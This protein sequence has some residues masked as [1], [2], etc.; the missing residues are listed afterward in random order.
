MSSQ[1]DQR[2][3]V[4]ADHDLAAAASRAL[5]EIR[6]PGEI[7]SAQVLTRIAQLPTMLRT[8]GVLPTLA[9]YAAKGGSG[10]TAE[11]GPDSALELAYMFVGIALREQVC[12]ALGIDQGTDNRSLDVAF[13]SDLAQR[14]RTEP[15]SHN[16]VSARLEQFSIWLRRL[17]EA[18]ERQQEQERN[19]QE[20]AAE[21]QEATGD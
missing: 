16:R 14:L 9:F 20:A 18:L 5:T 17:A 12:S 7:V 15:Y 21:S 13:L 4:R 6:R 2:W 1:A 8:S 11:K 19:A 10:Q 3:L